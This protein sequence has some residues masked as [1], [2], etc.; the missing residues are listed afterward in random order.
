MPVTR[1]FFKYWLPIVIWMLVIFSASG[2]RES[3]E[4]SSRIIGPI[5]HWL[6]PNLPAHRVNQ[7]VT[8]ARKGAHLTEY[9]VL[10]ILFWRATRPLV[11]TEA[12]V[13]NWKLAFASVAFVALYAGTDEFHQTLVPGRQGS[14]RDV[15][16]DTTGAIGGM[17]FLWLLWKWRYGR[18]SK[19]ELPAS[20]S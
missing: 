2:D 4:R 10:A 5:L 11:K 3:F 13:W 19:V 12:K 18:Q 1:L 16:I 14:V 15:L 8:L 6:M 7:I 17:I 20:S 9:A